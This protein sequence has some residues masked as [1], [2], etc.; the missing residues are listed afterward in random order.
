VEETTEAERWRRVDALLQA[1]LERAPAEQ[2]AFLDA[3]CAGDPLLRAEVESL[4]GYR[5]DAEHF[6]EAPAFALAAGLFADDAT[7]DASLRNLADAMDS[8][9]LSHEAEA[10]AGAERESRRQMVKRSYWR[11]L[12]ILRQLEARGALS[13]VDRK[14][15]E[16]LQ[17]AV[18]KYGR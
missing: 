14:F 7:D 16:R 18:Q 3:A 17:A 9:A 2:P 13:E 15:M 1:A 8:T 5:A 4:L 10:A 6:I 11:A 12:D